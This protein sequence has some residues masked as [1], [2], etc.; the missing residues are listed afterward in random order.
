MR[1]RRLPQSHPSLCF[2][3]ALAAGTLPTARAFA[4]DGDDA[5]R[6]CVAAADDGQLARD[7]GKYGV[8]WTQ[9]TACAAPECPTIVRQQCGLWLQ[10]LEDAIPTVV[11]AMVDAL[12]RDLTDVSVSADGKVVATALDGRPVSL[13]PGPHEV[14]F[15]APGHPAVVTTVILRA[16]EKN[17]VVKV[18]AAPDESLITSPPPVRTTFWD[19]RAT[20]TATLLAAGLVSVGVGVY[21]A[22]SSQ[23]EADHAAT[24]REGL[25]AGS[26]VAPSASPNC[27]A[28]SSD[29]DAQNRDATL[30]TAFYVSGGVLAAAGAFV[31]L[32]WPKHPTAIPSSSGATVS[33]RPILGLGSAGLN[34]EIRFR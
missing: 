8:A 26:C 24:Q 19:A 3:V 5:K 4:A 22:E 13:D 29:V 18:E 30:G 32:A 34:A 10:Q 16:G 21:F 27:H 1:R 2:I 15:E 25:L 17:R 7:T 31:W 6:A 33:L 23:V 12:G 11:F 28:L 20:T 9:F 14:R